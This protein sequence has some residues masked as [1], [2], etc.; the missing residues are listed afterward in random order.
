LAQGAP[1]EPACGALRQ[2]QAP[3]AVVPKPI[4]ARVEGGKVTLA[5]EPRSVTVVSVE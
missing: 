5:L 4:A 1:G 3:N 2:L